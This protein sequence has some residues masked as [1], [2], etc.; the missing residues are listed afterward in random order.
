MLLSSNDIHYSRSKKLELKKLI[1]YQ[2]NTQNPYILKWRFKACLNFSQG[3]ISN[4][5]QTLKLNKIKRVLNEVLK[6]FHL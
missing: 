4:S 2:N 6:N 1:L 5:S 3:F